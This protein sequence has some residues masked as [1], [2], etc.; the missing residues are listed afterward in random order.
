M[1]KGGFRMVSHWSWGWYP[2]LENPGSLLYLLCWRL[3]LPF[4]IGSP[5]ENP[6]SAAGTYI[7]C[8]FKKI[9]IEDILVCTRGARSTSKSTTAFLRTLSSPLQHNQ[10]LMARKRRVNGLL[11]I[12]AL[13]NCREGNTWGFVRKIRDVWRVRDLVTPLHDQ[14]R[15]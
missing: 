4:G 13:E 15:I 12:F 14:W 2:H 5:L 7:F 1:T 6:G 11:M 8:Q 9:E 10:L 3:P